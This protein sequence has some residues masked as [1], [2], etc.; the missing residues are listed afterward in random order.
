MRRQ[1]L[2][3]RRNILVDVS[4]VRPHE[5]SYECVLPFDH[6]CVPT[7]AFFIRF[8]NAN[9]RLPCAKS[10]GNE[11][12]PAHGTFICRLYAV[13]SNPIAGLFSAYNLSTALTAVPLTRA[14]LN[15]A[16]NRNNES[17][18]HSLWFSFRPVKI[19]FFSWQRRPNETEDVSAVY[20]RLEQ[21]CDSRIDSW[22]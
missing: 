19:S 6:L 20:W 10:S 2:A 7:W 16:M 15:A 13:H 5:S 22:W 14:L 18:C 1:Q 4:I 9:D 8:W 12:Y 21:A 17:T 11:K 3:V